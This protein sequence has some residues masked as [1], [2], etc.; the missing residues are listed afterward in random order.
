[1]LPWRIVRITAALLV[2]GMAV[3]VGLG[4]DFHLSVNITETFSERYIE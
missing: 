1:M 3:A 4:N 2:I